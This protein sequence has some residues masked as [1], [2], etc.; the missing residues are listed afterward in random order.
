M[1]A[2]HDILQ[3]KTEAELRFFVDNPS[4]Y[5]PE[6]V[7]A[8]QRELR[9]RGP[10]AA[11]PTAAAPQPAAES[12]VSPEANAPG[13]L[14]APAP[15]VQAYAPTTEQDYVSEYAD[16]EFQPAQRPWLLLGSVA[17]VFFLAGL[18][19]WFKSPGAGA[20]TAP[21]VAVAPAQTPPTTI[22]PSAAGAA[23]APPKL[24]TAPSY[25]IPHYDTESYVNKALAQ[26]P[27]TEKHDEQL[28]SQYH[29][30]SNLFWAA[31]N[32]SAH[33]IQQAQ[34]GQAN[35]LLG[36]QAQFVLGLWHDF[37][38]TQVY[39]YSF[40]PVMADHLARMKVVAQYQREALK[41]LANDVDAQRPPRLD[42]N[43]T[44]THQ[45]ALSQLLAALEQ[46]T[47]STPA[48]K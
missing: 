47:V 1:A 12:A 5:Q 11:P 40:G 46:K 14:G 10:S 29:A 25:P 13:P 39:R 17:A 42:D 3:L 38:R 34:A 43:Q 33:L 6:L 45:Q 48:H 35:P 20:I 31:Q 23:A 7:A 8:A 26:V 18:G 24:E 4:Y 2:T 44:L 22:V 15:V 37:D 41:E 36:E 21:P 16:T 28:L 27:S 19:F 9:R 32:P 30:V